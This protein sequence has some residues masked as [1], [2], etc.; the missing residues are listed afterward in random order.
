MNPHATKGECANR[1]LHTPCPDGYLAWHAWADKM[2][3][4]HKTRKCPTC[5]MWA[6]WE[7]KTKRATKGGVK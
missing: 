6:I 2:G 3:K 5:G 7:P 4:T 1:H